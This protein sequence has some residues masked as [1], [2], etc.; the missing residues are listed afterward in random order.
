MSGY[1]YLIRPLAPLVFGNGKPFDA[2][3]EVSDIIFP[4]PS[5][6]AGLVRTQYL[7]QNKLPLMKATEHL[8]L[9]QEDYHHLQG[10]QQKGPFLVEILEGN[11]YNFFV[12][13]PADALY[14]LNKASQQIELIRLQP[15]EISVDLGSDLP[16]GLLPVMMDKPIKGKPQAG[17]LF[18]HIDDIFAWQHGENLT[19][20][21]VNK[22]GVKSLPIDAR[23]HVAIDDATLSSEE[24]R[25]FQSIAYDLGAARKDNRLGWEERSYGFLLLSDQELHNGLVKFGGEGRLSEMIQVEAHASLTLNKVTLSGIQKNNGIKLTLL[26]PAI[27]ENGYLPAWLDEQTLTGTLPY[28]N[29]K[30]TLKA[31]AMERWIPVSGWDMQQHKPKAMRKAVA[32]GAVYWFEILAGDITELTNLMM[33]TISD[34]SQDRKDGFG[35]VTIAPWA[36]L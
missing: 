22:R 2:Q 30:V 11:K 12:A 3:T 18:W 20:E 26:T 8:T 27:F 10:M 25:L 34:H 36:K 16:N 6:A 28:T 21:E 23:T 24:G 1:S 5:S 13:K 15:Q 35:V 14:L 17:A 31:C 4:L 32:A 19:Y 29:I 9:R 33:Q 7:Q